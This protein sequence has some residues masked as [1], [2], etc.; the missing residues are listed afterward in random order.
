MA[1]GKR[2]VRYSL[3]R[4]GILAPSDRLANTVELSQPGVLCDRNQLDS[5]ELRNVQIRGGS[6]AAVAIPHFHDD[7]HLHG[8]NA[9]D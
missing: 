2:T 9:S 3:T 1:A 6:P 8:I 7:G 4:N 5:G